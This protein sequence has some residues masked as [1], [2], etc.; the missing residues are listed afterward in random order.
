MRLKLD[1]TPDEVWRWQPLPWNQMTYEQ[2]REHLI[3]QL[4]WHYP[5]MTRERAAEHIDAVF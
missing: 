3:E 5:T 4:L 2:K 1:G